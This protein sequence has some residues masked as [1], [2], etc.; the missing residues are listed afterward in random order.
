M[1]ER[2]PQEP[3]LAVEKVLPILDKIAV[4]GGLTESQ[5]YKVFKQ[6]K[7]IHYEPNEVVFEEGDSASYIYIVQSGAVRLVFDA[8]QDALLKAMLGPGNCFGETSLIGIQPHSVTAIAE[9]KLEL[10]V[11][12]G[13]AL[14]DLM[15]EDQ[16][17]FAMLVLNIARESCRR[18]FKTNEQLRACLRHCPSS[19]VEGILAY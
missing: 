5:L 10:L 17:L 14:N 7:Q 2:K 4:F 18:L 3:L 11:L 8:K 12:S 9:Q 1:T 15:L 13:G 6:L 16:E 19:V